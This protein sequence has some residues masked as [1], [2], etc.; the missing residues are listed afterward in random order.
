MQ[1][2]PSPAFGFDALPR[3]PASNLAAALFALLGNLR[4]LSEDQNGRGLYREFHRFEAPR[5]ENDSKKRAINQSVM[6]RLPAK[7]LGQ[8]AWLLGGE[9]SFGKKT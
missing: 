9:G 7:L 5:R 3:S 4:D 1:L 8:S 2:G 6:T